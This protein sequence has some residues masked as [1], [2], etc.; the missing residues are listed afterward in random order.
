MKIDLIRIERIDLMIRKKFTGSPG[1]LAAK[2]GISVRTLYDTLSFMKE[3]LSAPI[4]Y[5]PIKK[6]YCYKEEGSFCF[7]YQRNQHI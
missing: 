7:K 6:S 4:I 2:L 5:N 3:E 1:E